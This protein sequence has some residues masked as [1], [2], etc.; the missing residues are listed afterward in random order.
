M[1]IN[2]EDDYGSGS[3]RTLRKTSDLREL[4]IEAAEMIAGMP[5]IHALELQEKLDLLARLRRAAEE[6]K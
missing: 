1:S 2:Q 3:F 6:I 4:L 5:T